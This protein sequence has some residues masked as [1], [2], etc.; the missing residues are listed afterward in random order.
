[1][2]KIHWG[3]LAILA[4]G[5]LAILILM[6]FGFLMGDFSANSPVP[7]TKEDML[8]LLE[9]GLFLLVF[10][11]AFV[12]IFVLIIPYT[13]L[14]YLPKRMKRNIERQQFLAFKRNQSA[15]QSAEPA[16]P[17]KKSVPLFPEIAEYLS[18]CEAQF[19]EIEKDRKK[20]L[21]SI[22]QHISQKLKSGESVNLSFICTHNSRRSQ[23]GQI[24]AAV[25]SAKFGLTNIQTHSGGTEETT[26]NKRAVEACRRAGLK[27][28][29]TVGT[30]P[31]YSVRFSDEVGAL[32]CYSKTFDTPANPQLGFVAIMTCSDADENCPVIDGAEH[33]FSLT[34]EDPK[35]ADRTHE[36]SSKYD[37]RCR[38]IATEMLYLFSLID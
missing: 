9:I 28:E 18:N 14:I 17:E 15:E 22:A 26:F 38:Q 19:S 29:G 32:D 13:V 8:H 6:S 4:I 34:Y 20:L 35:V 11:Y 7:L 36:E 2:I 25:A 1:M 37:E 10:G 33:R 30:N 21:N 24:W 5:P 3:Y 27:I 16:K 31:R 12:M 23:F